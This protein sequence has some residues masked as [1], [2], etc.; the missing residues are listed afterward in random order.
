MRPQLFQ[1]LIVLV[2]F[3]CTD[4]NTNKRSDTVYANYTITAA[5]ETE[6]V[7]CVFQFYNGSSEG[8]TLVLQPP[9]AVLFDDVAVP[10][11]SARLSGAY[12]ELQRPLAGFAGQHTITFKNAEGKTYVETFTFQPF[13]LTNTLDAP[14]ARGDLSLQIT[15]LQARE[16]LRVLLTD[17]AFA[18]P[19]INDIDTVKNGRLVLTQQALRNVT[20]GPV[21]LHLYK[22]E[23]RPLK[24][25][26]G[27]GG[28]L[29]ITYS[30]S[31]TFE[32]V[33]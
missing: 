14:V 31:R 27:R 21:I 8:P 32:L 26:P 18:T 19:D 16:P 20:N 12:Y 3:A 2:L 4:N 28:K 30:L 24:N 22:E 1:I 29:S 5:E 33:D 15:G 13:R 17:T 23:E 7:T 11:D 9:A 10:V 6:N 25:P